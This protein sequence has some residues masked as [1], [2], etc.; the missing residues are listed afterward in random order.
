MKIVICGSIKFRKEMVVYRDKLNEMGHFGII[1]PVMEELARGEKPEL[2][3]QIEHEHWKVK[4]EGGFI[5]WHYDAIVESD[6]IFG[7]EF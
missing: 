3:A 7:F 5:K 2:M 1:H 4:K 6:G